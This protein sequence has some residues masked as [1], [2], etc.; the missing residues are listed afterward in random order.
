MLGY[1]LQLR[2]GLRINQRRTLAFA[3]AAAQ[4]GK[5]NFYCYIL[6]YGTLHLC[7]FRKFC[8]RGPIQLIFVVDEGE[9]IQ[10]PQKAG[11]QR[12]T[13]ETPFKCFKNSFQL[14]LKKW[15]VKLNYFLSFS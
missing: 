12:Q 15:V 5:E 6:M 11:H 9:R 14:Q 10:I 7:R 13:S 1:K 4:T 2:S 8:H 3:A